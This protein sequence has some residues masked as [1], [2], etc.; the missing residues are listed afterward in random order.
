MKEGTRVKTYSSGIISDPSQSHTTTRRDGD[1]VSSRRVRLTLLEGRIDRGIVRSHVK[2]LVNQLILMSTGLSDRL[3]KRPGPR[4]TTYK[5]KW[6]GWKPLYKS[7]D[8]HWGGVEMYSRI[9]VEDCELDPRHVRICK[10]VGLGTIDCRV[11]R[12][13]TH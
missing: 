8:V 7:A 9:P 6:N 4:W 11:E 3:R 13:V 5:C 2:A 1:C 10:R 12:V